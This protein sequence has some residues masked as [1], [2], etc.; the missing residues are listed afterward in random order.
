MSIEIAGNW[1]AG[2]AFDV[3][4]LS[5][6]Y[7]GPN[8]FGHAK[9]ENVRSDMGELVYQL[10]YRSDKSKLDEIV[11]LLDKITGIEQFDFLMPIPP[12]DK[13]RAFQPVN[14]DS[15]CA[16]TTPRR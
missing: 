1:N 9:Y 6:T 7:L 14:G 11:K 4:T 5:S 12:T 3:H 13:A 15:P 8:E 16:W 10:K 2:Q